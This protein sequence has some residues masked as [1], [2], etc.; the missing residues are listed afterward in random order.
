MILVGALNQLWSMIETQQVVIMLLIC[1]VSSPAATV[2]FF[3]AVF[4]VAAFD[5]VETEPF[6]NRLLRLDPTEPFNEKIDSLGMG[7][8]YLLNNLGSLGIVFLVYLLLLLSI[9]TLERIGPGF[10]RR[11]KQLKNLLQWGHLITTIKETS[12]IIALAAS[13][14]LKTIRW[15]SFG[16][17][18]HN[19]IAIAFLLLLTV[20][21]A[22]SIGVM[23]Y[24]FGW[25]D[26]KHRFI[27][28]KKD[29]ND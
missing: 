16:D 26:K 20:F 2:I 19:T 24:D 5:I 14:F 17:L 27:A 18:I 22:Y 1:N 23:G 9:P 6:L 21:P 3:S 7:S 11:A 4:E 15:E 8:I 29:L 13:I 28:W 25:A 12:T 10:R